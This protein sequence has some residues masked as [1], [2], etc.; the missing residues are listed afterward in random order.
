MKRLLLYPFIL[1]FI[2]IKRN[3]GKTIFIFLSIIGFNFSQ[4]YSEDIHYTTTADFVVKN[5]TDYIYFFSK[6]KDG[7]YSSFVTKNPLKNN[8]YNYTQ[9]HDLY[10]FFQG[11]AWVSVSILT[12]LFI[13]GIYDDS[14]S[15]RIDECLEE[16]LSFLIC[17]EV[18]G[19]EFYYIAI[20]RLIKKS[21]RQLSNSYH[22][23]AR[24]LKIRNFND[25]LNCPKFKTRSQKRGELLDKLL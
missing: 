5:G 25:I 6:N 23:M 20:G 15:W 7:D 16:S 19:S 2:I 13:I 17:C 22:S 9:T 24:E 12:I 3:I 21:D 14:V 1:L 8:T 18:E 11:I 10:I 4:N